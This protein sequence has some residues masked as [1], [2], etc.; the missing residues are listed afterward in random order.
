MTVDKSYHKQTPSRCR[1]L[2]VTQVFGMKK[3]DD[4]LF[5]AVPVF[6]I[7]FEGVIGLGGLV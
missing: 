2:I 4:H 6:V 7:R 1:S 3:G 5:F